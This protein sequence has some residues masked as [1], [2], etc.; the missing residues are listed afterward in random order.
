MVKKFSTAGESTTQLFHKPLVL[1]DLA[2]RNAWYFLRQFV[3]LAF[4]ASDGIPTRMSTPTA[5]PAFI[6]GRNVHFWNA[7]LAAASISSESP[8]NTF[9]SATVPSSPILP[10]RIKDL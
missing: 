3:A 5:F 8:R 9:R 10:F 1:H 6:A 4:G 7:N 2:R